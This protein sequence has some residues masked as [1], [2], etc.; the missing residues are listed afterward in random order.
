VLLVVGG[1]VFAHRYLGML[2]VETLAT[3]LT[4]LEGV[5]LRLQE[6]LTMSAR[7]A[8]ATGDP[9]WE[10]RYRQYDEQLRR[11]IT[12]AVEIAPDAAR[13]AAEAAQAVDH[14]LDAREARAFELTRQGRRGEAAAVFDASYDRL[15]DAYVHHMS[16][17]MAGV[18]R[19]VV[20]RLENHRRSVIAALTG[21]A[22]LLLFLALLWVR[23]L[24]LIQR[25]MRDRT[26]AEDQLRAAQ[27]GL[28]V[29]VAERTREVAASREQY[30]SLVENIDAIPFEWDP[31]AR[32][33]VYLAPQAARLFGCPVE[34]LHGTGFLATALHPD[35]H[36]RLAG[37]IEA[38]LAGE[39]GGT[40]DCPMVT[41]AQRTVHVRMV[42]G[43]RTPTRTACGVMLDITQQKQLEA[44]LQQAQ[45]LESIGRLA[46]GVAHEINTPVQFVTDSVQFVHD[47]MA[48]LLMVLDKHRRSTERAAAGQ[49][50]PELAR[51]AQAAEADAD[52]QYLSEQVPRA[53]ERALDGLSRVAAIVQS[54]KIF[55]HPRKER[56]A[57]DLGD[58]ISSTLTIAR[59]EYKYVADL[60]T[61]FA[62]LPQV[63][64][65]AGELN[66]VILNLVTNAA[67]A[68]GDA[69]AGTEQRGRI[70]LTTRRD[71]DHV[72]IAIADTGTGIPP[73]VRGRIFE[74]FFTTKDVGKGTGQGLSHARAV[75]VEKHHGSL[76]FDTE[77]G[78]GTTFYI[79]IPIAEPD[80]IAPEP[81]AA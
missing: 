32:R 35:E 14:E 67:H 61:E 54:M 80:A 41:A 65:Y 47:S 48:D 79:R 12:E 29:R 52:L 76:T 71:G 75:I 56:C 45:K 20:H 49:P 27:A 1:T 78:V 64:C 38:F 24:R 72:V 43:E 42:L 77:V 4:R 34:E 44:E 28:E 26:A 5:I 3:Q 18:G 60:E 62:D 73:A 53:L 19:V 33:M 11:A 40:L 74:P 30:R 58:A 25:Y 46:A 7:M 36:A 10:Q 66:Q 16:D 69:V 68:I 81:V 15:Q 51:D 55:A 39:H 31:T 13:R 6:I 2:E 59:N 23:M 63:S 9:Q 22:V 70:T 8:A 21:S 57:V 37:P 50:A 17:L